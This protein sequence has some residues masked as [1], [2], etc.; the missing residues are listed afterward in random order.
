MDTARISKMPSA[1][2]TAA[3]AALLTFKGEFAAQ[4]EWPLMAVTFRPASADF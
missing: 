2:P 4:S 1:S 3:K